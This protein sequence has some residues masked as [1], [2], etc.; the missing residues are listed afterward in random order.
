MR[1]IYSVLLLV[2][3]Y[4]LIRM[5]AAVHA[6]DSL[7]VEGVPQCGLSTYENGFLVVVNACNTRVS[8][9]WTSPGDVWG[10]AN[11]GPRERQNTGQSGDAVRR[12]GGVALFTCPDYSSPEEPQGRPLEPHYRGPYRC[13]R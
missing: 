13:R 3:I 6:Q 8:I 12:A 5:P 4:S 11:L 7:F 9:T 10:S 2:C 1:S